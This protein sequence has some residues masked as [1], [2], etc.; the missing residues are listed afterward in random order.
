MLF[1]VS[2]SLNVKALDYGQLHMQEVLD[3]L[4]SKI[5]ISVAT[6]TNFSMECNPF[7]IKFGPSIAHTLAVSTHLWIDALS[8]EVKSTV[9]LT[10][11]VV[12]NDSNI[13]IRFGQTGSTDNILLPSRTC[14]FYSWRHGKHRM[15]HVAIEGT[16]WSWSQPFTV[17]TNGRQLVSFGNSTG[18]PIICAK[19]VSLSATQKLITF[20]GLLVLTNRLVEGFE[21]KLVKYSQEVGSK[22]VVVDELHCVRGNSRSASIALESNVNMAMRLKFATSTSLSWTGDIPLKPNSKWGQ[23][24]LVKVPLQ[25]RGQF[26]SIWARIVTENIAGNTRVLAIL[27]PLYMIKSYLPIPVTVQIE[28]PSLRTSLNATINGRGERQQ[29]Y[30]PGTFEHSH[31]LTFQFETGVSASNPY[32]PLSYSSVEQRKFFK[33]PENEDIDCILTELENQVDAFH[34]PFQIDD[35]HVWIPAEQPQTHVQVKYEDAGLVSSTL[36]LELQPWCFILNTLGC[37]VSLIAED[38]ELCQVPHNGIITPPKLDVS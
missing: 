9:I 19:V 17:K 24:W 7:A 38:I 26:L 6:E 18:Y 27:S 32:V 1:D 11:V 31:Q 13:D 25:E 4:E 28:T 3:H 16:G 10:R 22:P 2:G 5:Q 34:W 23:P 35:T 20:S 30:C 12:A 36:L 33:R 8:P 15:L 21:M 29:L 14:Y 37:Q